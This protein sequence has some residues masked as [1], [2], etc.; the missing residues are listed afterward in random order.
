MNRDLFRM[1]RFLSLVLRHKPEEIG[2]QLDGEGWVDIGEL[3][4]KARAHGQMLDRDTVDRIVATSDKQRFALSPD[5]RLIRAN[6]GH[7]TSV[8]LGYEPA[9][10]PPV[11]FH[12]TV[13][14]ALPAIRSQ[15]LVAM[16]RH[17][18]HLSADEATATIVGIRRGKPVILRIDAHAMQQAGHTFFC[19]PNRVWLTDAVPSQFISGFDGA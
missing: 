7:S 11:L 6:Q 19:T 5:G 18:V 3:V 8:D 16:Q 10:P 12:G 1:S 4:E 2:L 9:D 15:G 13:A 14:G 17:H